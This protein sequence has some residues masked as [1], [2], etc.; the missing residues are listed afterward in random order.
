MPMTE[1][2]GPVMPTSVMYPI[3]FGRIRSSPVC[4]VGVGAEK[5]PLPLPSRN[6]PM[7]IFSDVA[8][9]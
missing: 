2:A 6:Q 3:P 9:A 8:S 1:S 4:N 5:G 7:A